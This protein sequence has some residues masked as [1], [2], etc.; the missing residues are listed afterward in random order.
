MYIPTLRLAPQKKRERKNPKKTTDAKET[1]NSK[2]APHLQNHHPRA[3]QPGR[4]PRRPAPQLDVPIRRLQHGHASL[5]RAPDPALG[6]AAREGAVV[7]GE[8]SGCWGP[9]VCCARGSAERAARVRTPASGGGAGGGTGTTKTS[10]RSVPS[11]YQAESRDPGNT[12]RSVRDGY[13][14]AEDKKAAT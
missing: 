11:R 6:E 3:P 1:K 14:S 4:R 8:G 5:L 10:T 13:E 2:N 12:R 7:R 9:W